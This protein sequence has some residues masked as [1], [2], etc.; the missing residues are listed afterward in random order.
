MP[1]STSQKA[2]KIAITLPPEMLENVKRQVKAGLYS[3]TSE[4]IREALRDWQQQHANNMR[5]A[6]IEKMLA[7]IEALPKWEDDNFLKE[8]REELLWALGPGHPLFIAEYKRQL[9]AIAA[10]DNDD[11]FEVIPEFEEWE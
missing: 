2:E 1:T 6:S 3:S 10:D 9:A 7:N 8:Q 5:V 11:D 4:V